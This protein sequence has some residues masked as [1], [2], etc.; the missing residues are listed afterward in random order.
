MKKLMHG[1]LQGWSVVLLVCLAVSS[2]LLP[3]Y[4]QAQSE[5][6]S[7]SGQVTDQS[8]AVVPGVHVEIKNVDT[9]VSQVTMTNGEGFYVFP[10]LKPGNYLMNVSK[11]MFRTVSVTGIK[12]SVQ[13]D[14]SRNFVLQV[15]SSSESVTVTAEA[16]EVVNTMDG[17]VG[18]VINRQ[19]VE[20]M[21][22][23]GRSYQTLIALSPGVIMTPV[24]VNGADQGQFS[25]NGMRTNSNYF[26]VDGVSANFGVPV[27]Q[28]LAQATS[29]SLPSTNIQGGFSN[30]VSVDAMEEFK[31]QTSTFAPEFGRTPGAQISIVSRS[32]TN[33]LHGSLFEYFRNDVT[34]AKDFFDIS[35]PPLRFNDFGGTIGGPVIIPKLY[36]GRDKTFF[37]FSYEGQRFVLPQPTAITTVPT[38]AERA[39]AT[40]PIARA[41]LDAFALPNGPAVPTGGAKLE[42]HHSTKKI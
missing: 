16:A 41:L 3:R 23:N 22:L 34:D 30:L 17:S 25:A 40:N 14:L 8:G 37:F 21:P 26:T 20:N 12:L 11:Q 10:V 29:G 31:I 36:N 24:S 9:N 13:Q 35:K 4:L 15:G 1:E 42:S 6:A 32:G 38:A 18:T 33:D 5:T 7:V 27:F 39:A 19:F 28:G 2:F